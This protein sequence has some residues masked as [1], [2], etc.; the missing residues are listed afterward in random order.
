MNLV[1]AK[2]VRND[3]PECLK[4]LLAEVKALGGPSL[5]S[6]V[7]EI[8]EHWLNASCPHGRAGLKFRRLAE[9]DE[10]SNG[11]C[12][13]PENSGGIDQSNLFD[14]R[15]DATKDGGYPMREHGP[16]YGSHSMHDSFSDESGPDSP[17]TY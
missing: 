17:G 15:M 14:A 11:D 16:Q 7:V 1:L 8:P 10:L 13:D 2:N 4:A 5:E 12:D 9:L 3:C 6:Q